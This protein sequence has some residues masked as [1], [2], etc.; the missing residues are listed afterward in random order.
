MLSV[1]SGN[2][3]FAL[4]DV[5]NFYVSCERVFQPKLQNL[6]VVV[7]SN[8]DGCVISRSDE[9]KSIGV[10]MGAPLHLIEQSILK[11]LVLFSS[12]YPLYADLSRRFFETLKLFSN[13]IEQYSIDEVFLDISDYKTENLIELGKKIKYTVA[14]NIKL[15]V[16]VGIGTTKTLSKL[17]NKYAKE[18]KKLEGVLSLV[19][20]PNLEKILE[21]TEIK[22][23]WGLGYSLT[24]ALRKENIIN[25]LAFRDAKESWIK[26][27]FTLVG[28]KIQ[29]ELKEIP[30]LEIETI[31]SP[32][33]HIMMTRSFGKRVK[34]KKDM[35]EAIATY[36]TIATD[37]LLKEKEFTARI[38]VY[39]RLIQSISKKKN[40][41]YTVELENPTCSLHKIVKAALFALD[42]CF[43]HNLEYKKAGVILGKLSLLDSIQTS[44]FEKDLIDEE[45]DY[46][47]TYSKIR[48]KYGKKKLKL[49]VCG[50]GTQNW[51]MKAGLLSKRYT[52]RETDIRIIK[53]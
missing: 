18:V 17:A 2:K 48:E 4:V 28:F 14:K 50:F 29:Q 11:R 3:K 47:K 34:E 21:R 23:I 15:P 5:N 32:K 8:N 35:E 45:V 51:K 19:K 1:K 42:Q 41:L 37:K 24:E 25:A 7:L 13:S 22:K 46:M 20:H 40:I 49:A 44:L 6:P 39:L 10:K 43:I 27:R 33:K 38:T 9:A 16:C 30:C 26:K 12:N 36:A 53:I 31:H 52:T